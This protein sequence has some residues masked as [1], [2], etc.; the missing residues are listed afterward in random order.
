M[1]LLSHKRT[2]K[3]NLNKKLSKLIKRFSPTQCNLKMLIRP[4]EILNIKQTTMKL[5][6]NIQIPKVRKIIKAKIA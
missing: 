4:I 6:V 5:K 2:I 1:I 3:P